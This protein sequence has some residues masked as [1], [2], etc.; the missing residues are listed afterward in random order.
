M[1]EWN[2]QYSVGISRID[3]EHKKFIDII[4]KAIITKGHN[5][6]PKELKEVI[7]EITM[8]ALNHFATEETLM[9]EFNYTEY[10][11][12]KEEHSAFARKMI[13]YFNKILDGDYQITNE[14]LEYLQY[15]LVNHIRITDQ[16]YV[17]CFKENCIK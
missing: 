5:N 14:I 3:N 17:N 16:K 13:A 9:I 12:H 1:I 11:S 8:Y 6:N 4:N 2:D 10:E 15:W 7:H